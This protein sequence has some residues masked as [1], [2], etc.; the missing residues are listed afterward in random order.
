MGL[1]TR[2]IAGGVVEGVS[3]S[4]SLASIFHS[5][6]AEKAAA[7][8]IARFL[9]D[10]L[11]DSIVEIVDIIQKEFPGEVTAIDIYTAIS[12]LAIL[13][14]RSSKPVYDIRKYQAAEDSP[15]AHRFVYFM[16]Y[17]TAAY[18]R[19][20]A[21][22]VASILTSSDRE[23][24]KVHTGLP[25]NKIH[26]YVDANAVR[27]RPMLEH[28]VAVDDAKKSVI[29]ALKGTLSVEGAT[30]DIRFEYLPVKIW[31]QQF[32]VHS[33][34]WKAAQ[35][36]IAFPLL[37]A[38]VKQEL[39][40][41]PDYTLVVLGHSL[42]GGVAILLSALLAAEPNSAGFLTNSLTVPGRPIVCVGFEPAASID[43]ALAVKTK[44]LMY[45]VVNKNDIVPSL[46]RGAILDIK[47]VALKLKN[48]S[49]YF[50]TIVDGLLTDTL[51]A[52]KELHYIRSLANNEKLVPGGRVW[53]MSINDE[54]T[55]EIGEVLN[56]NQRFG[57]AR[58]IM[59][60]IT[61]H[62]PADCVI[63]FSSLPK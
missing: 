16:K 27:G 43:E 60:M 12:V 6:G 22:D 20:P 48:D 32:E 24:I 3:V 36:L 49:P 50:A 30:K 57:E 52:N 39:E 5:P 46:S 47:T 41:N 15:I 33:G 17:A 19:T 54:G 56:V 34:M 14:H 61:N 28:Y 35:D 21:I 58:F 8:V 63:S 51:D 29:V 1:V 38:Q 59:G 26:P 18:G 2:A 31:G 25:F 55:L 40:A 44:A 10:G 7:S 23:W 4:S 45:T 13:Q 9:P 37:L 42:G 62:A 11:G 53:A